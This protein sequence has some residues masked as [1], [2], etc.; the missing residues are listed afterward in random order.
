MVFVFSICAVSD[1]ARKHA[2]VGQMNTLDKKHR[3]REVE[4]LTSTVGVGRNLE[5]EHLEKQ[6]PNGD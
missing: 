5:I 2:V 6:K 4:T 3:F 1:L